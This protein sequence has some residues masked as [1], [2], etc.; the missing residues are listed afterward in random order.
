MQGAVSSG[1]VTFTL[2]ESGDDTV[3]IQ[4]E[5]PLTLVKGAGNK[6]KLNS[7]AE[8]F[9]TVGALKR[10]KGSI[11]GPRINARNQ[12]GKELEISASHLDFSPEEFE[13]LLNYIKENLLPD[14][15]LSV[16]VKKLHFETG[17]DFIQ[18]SQETDISYE[19]TEI[20]QQVST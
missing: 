15:E 2:P 14:S 5:E 20:Q 9:Q 12:D 16:Q 4:H 7:T 8:C 6:L 10:F 18:F 3:D 13:S 1:V 17:Y 11:G 19:N